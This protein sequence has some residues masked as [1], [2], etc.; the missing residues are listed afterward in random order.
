MGMTTTHHAVTASGD[1]SFEL[2]DPIAEARDRLRRMLSRMDGKDSYSFVLWALPPGKRL[3]QVDETM[4]SEYIQCAGSSD[5]MTVEIRTGVG[6][7]ATQYVVG[8]SSVDRSGQPDVT[9]PWDGYVATVYPDELFT[10]DEASELFGHYLVHATVPS[11]YTLRPLDLSAEEP[12][13]A[14]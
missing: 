2:I 1:L 8:R 3:D 13:T 10:A 9:I 14:A 12:T 11:E 5:A 4:A 7:D 6:T